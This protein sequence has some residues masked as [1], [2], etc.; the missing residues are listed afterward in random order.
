MGCQIWRGWH[1]PTAEAAAAEAEAGA[2]TL[3][4]PCIL[5]ALTAKAPPL[6]VAGARWRSRFRR[7]FAA[8]AA[9]AALSDA[10]LASGTCP[11]RRVH[12]PEVTRALVVADWG[13]ERGCVRQSSMLQL[14]GT[15]VR[16][17]QGQRAGGLSAVVAWEWMVSLTAA[18]AAAGSASASAA[19]WC[20]CRLALSAA[21]AASRPAFTHNPR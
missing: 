12:S 4:L 17:D 13:C 3:P 15:A 10:P 9:A 5:A 6:L 21:A 20:C 8:A 16:G 1:A 14:R 18:S 2:P 11:C 19:G 7:R